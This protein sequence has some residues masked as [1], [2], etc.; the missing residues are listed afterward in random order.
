M[1]R[2]SFIRCA[3]EKRPGKG[4]R[5]I[6]PAG[7]FHGVDYAGLSRAFRLIVGSNC[8]VKLLYGIGDV[9]PGA[10]AINSPSR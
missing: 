1:L 7:E 9:P 2:I 6:A 5:F 8:W 10:G 3:Q 4:R